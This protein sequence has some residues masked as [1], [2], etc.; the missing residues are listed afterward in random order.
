MCA[1]THTKAMCVPAH[2]LICADVC[3]CLYHM[4]A[5]D[6]LC[7]WV[8]LVGCTRGG[9][10]QA[11]LSHSPFLALCSLSD[12][13]LGVSAKPDSP[14]AHLVPGSHRHSGRP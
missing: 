5:K 12:T 9:G 4:C 6:R 2:G 13:S 1:L 7:A 10:G 11:G 3:A 14:W 8:C